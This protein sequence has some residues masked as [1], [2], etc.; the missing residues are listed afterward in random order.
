MANKGN[1]RNRGKSSGRDRMS[2]RGK[3]KE[4]E[5][6]RKRRN[7]IAAV[8]V[9][10]VFGALIVLVAANLPDPPPPTIYNTAGFEVVGNELHISKSDITTNAKF[11]SYDTGSAGVNF[12][13]VIGSDGQF[14]TAFDACD[15]CF[16]AKKGYYQQGSE[17]VCRRFQYSPL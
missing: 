15:V 11:F 17:M 2:K 1:S 14:H 12:F 16:D 3:F 6:A 13:A 5:A 9:L 10:F 4:I 7:I 8:V